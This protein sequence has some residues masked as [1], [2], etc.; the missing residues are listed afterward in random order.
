MCLV[1]G[2]YVALLVRVVK[3]EWKVQYGAS[4]N[5]EQHF[6]PPWEVFVDDAS[7]ELYVPH[8]VCLI[9]AA[10]HLTMLYSPTFVNDVF[11]IGMLCGVVE[12][13]VCDDVGWLLVEFV[14]GLGVIEVQEM[15]DEGQ[16]T[17]FAVVGEADY[18]RAVPLH[19]FKAKCH[20]LRMQEVVCIEENEE[21]AAD[22]LQ[23]D[24]A[25]IRLS[26][27]GFM[28]DLESVVALSIFLCD[29]S[30]VV[31]AAVIYEDGF[32]VLVCLAEYAVESATQVLLYII[33]W[34]D[35]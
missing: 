29:S 25:S 21:F 11:R 7:R 24:I 10:P 14:V 16:H 34:Y 4:L 12:D 8:G 30:A 20:Q 15:L 27:V 32:P 13:V 31:C 18:I 3:I 2:E 22:V 26:A 6:A 28:N 23:S 5:A 33:Y 19:S 35:D 17:V 9:H 1:G